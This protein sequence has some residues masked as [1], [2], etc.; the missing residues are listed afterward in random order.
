LQ[1]SEALGIIANIDFPDQWPTLF[2]QVIAQ[3]QTGVQQ[4]S[5]A[6]LSGVTSMLECAAA[7]ADRFHDVAD[8]ESVEVRAPLLAMLKEFAPTLTEVF[9]VLFT[10]VGPLP[11]AS[12]RQGLTNMT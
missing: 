3:L 6:S 2:P 5:D 4:S 9:K 11:H 7:V 10:R 8:P 12:D 1:L